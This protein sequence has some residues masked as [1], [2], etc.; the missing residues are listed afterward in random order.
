MGSRFGNINYDNW[1]NNNI[2]VCIYFYYCLSLFLWQ[3]GLWFFISSIFIVRSLA[4][5]WLRLRF[6]AA[7]LK[8]ISFVFLAFSNF[9]S[10]RKIDLFF[11]VRLKFTWISFQS[12]LWILYSAT[13]SIGCGIFIGNS[14]FLHEISF[15]FNWFT[16]RFRTRPKSF[17]NLD[18]VSDMSA[19]EFPKPIC[20]FSSK[21]AFSSIW[22]VLTSTYRFNFIS[23]NI[24]S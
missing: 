15:L 9:F 12:S 16:H 6:L 13:N 10:R 2:S 18:A 14:H 4:S 11:I 23:M 19:N 1:I 8:I 20:A 5:M 21:R 7:E 17:F 3:S 22:T 24:Y